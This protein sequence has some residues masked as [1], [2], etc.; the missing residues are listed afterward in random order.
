VHW[1][2]ALE[3]C[4]EQLYWADILAYKYTPVYSLSHLSEKEKKMNLSLL[5]ERE[6]EKI[7]C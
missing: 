4:I 2:G 3:G 5:S 7:L 1:I 6:R